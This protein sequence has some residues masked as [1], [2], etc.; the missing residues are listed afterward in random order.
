MHGN[1]LKI[2]KTENYQGESVVNIFDFSRP[3]VRTVL[4]SERHSVDAALDRPHFKK[5]NAHQNA[6]I[7]FEVIIFSF[8]SLI[9]KLSFSPTNGPVAR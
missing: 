2:F 6:V 5:T 8:T 9:D 4:P 1:V 7:M 3:T